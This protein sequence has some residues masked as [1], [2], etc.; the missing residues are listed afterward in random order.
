MTGRQFENLLNCPIEE[1]NKE[2]KII[3]EI[4]ETENHFLD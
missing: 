3:L 2:I 4:Y 1:R